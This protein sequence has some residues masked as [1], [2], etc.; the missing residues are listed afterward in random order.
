MGRRST[1][2]N[3]RAWSP[4]VF[5]FQADK[6]L[7]A[8]QPRRVVDRE[9]NTAAENVA[10]VP[11]DSKLGIIVFNTTASPQE[12]CWFKTLGHFCWVFVEYVL[13]ACLGFLWV[14]WTKFQTSFSNSRMT[15]QSTF[16][17][18]ST[19]FY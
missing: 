16:E 3:N 7:Q 9:H 17:E 10:A 18:C 6:Q 1:S 15:N 8:L 5:K 14:L 13:S 2:E 12:G 19:N 11:A 4:W